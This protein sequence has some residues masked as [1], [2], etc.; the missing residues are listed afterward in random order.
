MNTYEIVC[1]CG[2]VLEV[3]EQGSVVCP[4]CGLEVD[5]KGNILE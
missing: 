5:D 2:Q 3:E 4:C 1:A